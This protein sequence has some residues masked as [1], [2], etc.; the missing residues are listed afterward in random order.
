MEIFGKTGGN[1]VNGSFFFLLKKDLSFTSN[2]ITK[3]LSSDSTLGGDS[4]FLF[5]CFLKKVLV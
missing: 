4:F 5:P 2:E 1:V 3:K